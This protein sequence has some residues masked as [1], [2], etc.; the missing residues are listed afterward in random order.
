MNNNSNFMTLAQVASI[1]GLSRRSVYEF[2]KAG[3]LKAYSFSTTGKSDR[4]R[5]KVTQSDLD[6]FLEAC[7]YDPAQLLPSQAPVT[8]LDRR[9][10]SKARNR[11]RYGR[12]SASTTAQ[13]VLNEV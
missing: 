8:P 7:R 10:G 5:W 12:Y 2:V 13:D 6:S 1:I 3:R 9:Y 11:D 4:R